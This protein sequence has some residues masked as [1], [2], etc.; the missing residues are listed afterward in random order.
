MIVFKQ[1]IYIAPLVAA[2][3]KDL[4]VQ[5][6]VGLGSTA[7]GNK[8]AA[9]QA[10]EQM[11]EQRRL[12]RQQLKAQAQQNKQM[13]DT[14]KQVA[15]QNPTVAGS[16]AG[17]MMQQQQ[18]A[19]PASV[20]GNLK[21]AKGAVKDLAIVSKQMGA[22]KT[23][24]RGLA[25]GATAAGASYLV[26]KA[27]QANAKR[28]GIDLGPTED[29]RKEH[30]KKLAKA[31]GLAT[32]AGLAIA[33]AK[34]GY[35]G[36][37]LRTA[38]DKV[39]NK[40]NLQKAG[41]TVKGAFKEQFVNTKAW[42]NAKGLKEKAKA[43]NAGG[44][45]MTAGFAALPVISYAGTKKAMK[46]Q[47]KQSEEAERTY[48]VK[49]KTPNLKNIKVPES[50][51]GFFQKKIRPALQKSTL[52]KPASSQPVASFKEA[53]VRKVLGGIS[54]FLGGGGQ[55]GT[56]DFTSK[57]SAQG[58]KSGNKIT[59]G[60]ANFLDKHK[61]LAVGGSV[62]VGSLMMKPWEL[63]SKTVNNITGAVDKNA[64]RYEKSQNKQ[65]EEE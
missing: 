23:V 64:M 52:P 34:K 20:L 59:Q 19:I 4:L 50:V 60:A 49:I 8:A 10:E 3:G 37:G 54:S 28:S 27:I 65:V 18:F 58:A 9:N 40:S 12:Q 56:A 53:P 48:S 26:D 14:L 36:N 15:K 62:A 61:T 44:L 6:A 38:A 2:L 33:G 31:A 11:Q 13:M 16:A 7:M 43:V 1:K 25:M 5:G 21:T 32:A 42:D 63:G 46:D 24:A 51:K 57:L 29:T 17:Q 47:A 45:A 41:K 55:Q 39:I 30:G 22:H 35:L